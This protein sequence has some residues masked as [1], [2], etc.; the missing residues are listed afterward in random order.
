MPEPLAYLNG[1]LLPA[2]QAVV[3]VYDAGFVQG[4]TVSEQLRTFRGQL[5]RLDD[6][7]SRLWRS[8]EIVDIDPG[9]T[10][11]QLAAAATE[12]VAENHRLL[13]AGDDLGLAIFVTPGPYATLAPA[14]DPDRQ[15]GSTGPT[16]GMHTYPLPFQ[17]WAEKYERGE[18]LVVPNVR[19]VPGACWPAE[20]K[21]RS[22][23]HYFLADRQASALE[24]GAK[25]LLTD[26]DGFVSETATANVIAYFAREGLVSPPRSTILPGVSLGMVLE[27][28]RQLNI[29]ASERALSPDDLQAAD[30]VFLSSTPSC[31]LP[32]ASLDGRAIGAGRPG[33]IYSRLLHAWG[34]KV[35]VD[36][37]AQARQ[38]ADRGSA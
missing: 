21:C 35:G 7:L 32:V 5:F 13:A 19:Q 38:F 12:L 14:T 25:A 36:I 2:S 31:L 10:R 1:R 11:A 34:E 3:P 28:A 17:L 15:A 27:L 4:A 24:P 30:E 16:V 20:L 9:L 29:S 26:V 23:M 33:P 6:H 37:A 8:L 22:R 18:A